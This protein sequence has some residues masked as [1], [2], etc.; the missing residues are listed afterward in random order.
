MTNK[1]QYLCR[2]KNILRRKIPVYKLLDTI[3]QMRDLMTQTW[4]HLHVKLV[5][6]S[7]DTAHKQLYFW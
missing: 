1:M 6:I 4:I 5:T 2:L 7:F 3:M